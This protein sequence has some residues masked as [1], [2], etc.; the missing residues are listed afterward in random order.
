[1][2]GDFYS[3]DVRDPA[4]AAALQSIVAQLQTVLVRLDDADDTPGVGT[5]LL[6]GGPRSPSADWLVCNGQEVNRTTYAAL[7]KAIGITFGST[8]ATSFT[9]PALTP[10]TSC[11][12]LIRAE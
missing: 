9:L 3:G 4:T 7:F 1:V 2:I 8:S 5:I 10:P 11:L 6:F 12:Y